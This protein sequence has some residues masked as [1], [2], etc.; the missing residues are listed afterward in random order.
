MGTFKILYLSFAVVCIVLK[1]YVPCSVTWCMRRG[2]ISVGFMKTGNWCVFISQTNIL[3][4]D[5]RNAMY[6]AM[7]CSEN[8]FSVHLIKYT[9]QLNEMEIG[10]GTGSQRVCRD[11]RMCCELRQ[12]CREILHVIL[13]QTQENLRIVL[14]KT[15]FSYTYVVQS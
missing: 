4:T 5:L 9:T 7:H 2:A 13:L 3:L 6:T 15:N 14:F 10:Q 1:L 12:V 8:R 11:T